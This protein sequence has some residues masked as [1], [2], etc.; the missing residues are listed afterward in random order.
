MSVTI[1][2]SLIVCL[3]VYLCFCFLEASK[4]HNATS[5]LFFE[6]FGGKIFYSPIAI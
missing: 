5:D 6:C 1:R 3:L 4:K 2:N